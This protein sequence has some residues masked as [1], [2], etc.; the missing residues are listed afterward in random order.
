MPDATWVEKGLR[1]LEPFNSKVIVISVGKLVLNL[2][3]IKKS[4]T[5]K[6]RRIPGSPAVLK[7]RS[8]HCRAAHVPAAPGAG[9]P[10]QPPGSEHNLSKRNNYCMVLFNH[11]DY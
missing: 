6:D 11:Q 9:S 10:S 5:M 1:D 7:H 4:L 2:E 8:P 3:D